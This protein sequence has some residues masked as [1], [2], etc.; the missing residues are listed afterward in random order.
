MSKEK[1]AFIIHA[2]IEVPL[3]II[4]MIDPSLIPGI[5]GSTATGPEGMILW[6]TIGLTIFSL[7]LLTWWVRNESPTTKL[8]REILLT[9]VLFHLLTAGVDVYAQVLETR[10]TLGWGLVAGHLFFAGMFALQL[11][12]KK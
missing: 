2:V 4:L 1:L 11:P 6:R 8:M 12:K 5:V 10:N 3:G 9:L 7:G